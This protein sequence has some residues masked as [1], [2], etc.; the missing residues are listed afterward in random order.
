MHPSASSHPSERAPA[1]EGTTERVD[2]ISV[3]DDRVRQKA[4]P[5]PESVQPPLESGHYL[6]VQG[7]GERLLVRLEREITRIGRG[8]NADL[9]LEE[10][11]VSRRH[12]RLVHDAEGA[13]VLDDRS[14]NGTFLNGRRVEQAPLQSGDVLMLGRVMLRYLQV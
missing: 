4:T 13:R 9:R 14:S 5:A 3:L 2:A 11:S 6:E 7:P 1:V 8:L 10:N 12:A